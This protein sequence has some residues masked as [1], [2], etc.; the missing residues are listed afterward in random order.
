MRD[1][2]RSQKDSLRTCALQH[3]TLNQIR[4]YG[5]LLQASLYV[6]NNLFINCS[7][8]D[9]SST[10]FTYCRNNLK[11]VRI[12]GFSKNPGCYTSPLYSSS[13]LEEGKLR[14][15]RSGLT[16]LCMYILSHNCISHQGPLIVYIGS[17][18]SS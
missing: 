5:K 2:R 15:M 7:L 4:N 6:C 10:C 13:K 11:K 12:F 17:F 14:F 8:F 16:D 3:K 1:S 18:F 9:L